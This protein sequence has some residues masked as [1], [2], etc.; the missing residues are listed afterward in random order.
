MKK[1]ESRVLALLIAMVLGVSCPISSMAASDEQLTD[2][3]QDEEIYVTSEEGEDDQ[4][5]R[6]QDDLLLDTESDYSESEASADDMVE[7]AVSETQDQEIGILDDALK[8]TGSDSLGRMI[9]SSLSEKVEEQKSNNGNNIFSVEIVG[10]KATVEYEVAQEAELVVGIYEEDGVKLLATGKNT[11]LPDEEIAEVEIDI[12][13]MPKYFYVKV[14]LILASTLEPLCSQFESPDYTKEM[15]EFFA[16]T[17]AD[18]DE[19]LVLNLDDNSA[20]NF[21]VFSEGVVRVSES[22]TQNTLIGADDNSLTYQFGNINA[23]IRDLKQGDILSYECLD[24]SI[25]ILLIESVNLSDDMSIAS[26]TGKTSSMEEAFEYIKIDSESMDEDVTID[27]SELEDGISYIGNLSNDEIENHFSIDGPD[28]D[29]A[30]MPR[31]KASSVDLSFKTKATF[32]IKRKLIEGSVGLSFKGKIKYYVSASHQSLTL[33]LD[34]EFSL[35][36]SSTGIEPFTIPLGKFGISPITG[37]FIEFTPSFILEPDSKTSVKITY[38]GTVGTSFDSKTKWHDASKKPKLKASIKNEINAFIGIS[39]EPK[40]AILSDK[41]ANAKMTAKTG[42][43]VSVDKDKKIKEDV[44]H[45]CEICYGG[46][47][48]YVISC[49]FSI[50]FLNLRS[51]KYSNKLE[52]N[53]KLDD[54]HYSYDNDEFSFSKCPHKVYPTEFTVKDTKGQP[55]QAAEIKTSTPFTVY[56][57]FGLRNENA[58]YTTK[59]GTIKGYLPKGNY[60]IVVSGDRHNEKTVSLKVKEKPGTKKITLSAKGSSDDSGDDD[61]D[62]DGGD[63]DDDEPTI[64]AKVSKLATSDKNSAIISPE[65]DLYVTG[66]NTYGELGIGENSK[67]TQSLVFRNIMSGVADVDLGERSGIAL[68]KDGTVWTWGYNQNGQIGNGT[69]SNAYTPVKVIDGVR[70]ISSVGATCGAVKNDNSLWMWGAK[71]TRRGEPYDGHPVRYYRS[72]LYP[73][74]IMDNVLYVCIHSDVNAV[75]KTDGS[76]WMWGCNEHGY[77]G[78]GNTED[79]LEPIKVLDNVK[80][81]DISGA[82][83]AAIKKDGSLWMWGLNSNGQFGNGTTTDSMIPIKILDNVKDV[84]V[85]G[86]YSSGQTAIIKEDDSLWISGQANLFVGSGYNTVTNNFVK[87]LSEVKDADFNKD[88]SHDGAIKKDGSLWRWGNNYFGQYGNGNNNSSYS[89]ICINNAYKVNAGMIQLTSCYGVDKEQDVILSAD[90]LSDKDEWVIAEDSAINYSSEILERHFDSLVPYTNYNFYVLSDEYYYDPLDSSNILYLTQGQTDGNGDLSIKYIPRVDDPDA[91]AFVVKQWEYKENEIEDD[92]IDEYAEVPDGLWMAGLSA[93][94]YDGTNQT[95]NV[96][97]YDG[98]TLLTENTDYTLSYKNNKK[99]FGYLPD[100]ADEAKK[101]PQITITMKGNYAGKQTVYFVIDPLSI[102]DPAAFDVTFKTSGKKTS[103]V[104]SHNGK[105]LKVNTDYTVR[106]EGTK[107][108]LEGIG[109]YVGTIKISKSDSKANTLVSMSKVKVAAVSSLTYKGSAYTETD[110][111]EYLKNAVTY[112]KSALVINE[113]FIVSKVIDSKNVGT[114]TVVLKGLKDTT[115]TNAFYG[116]KRIKI[117]IAPYPISGE[118]IAISSAEG[119]VRISAEY[120]KGG[121][122]PEI[123]IRYNG[124]NLKNGRDYTLTYKNNKAINNSGE[125]KKAPIISISGKGNFGGKTTV[126]FTIEQ[127]GFSSQNGIRVLAAD[128]HVSKDT[129]KYA[130]KISV[131]DKDGAL[132]KA[133]TDYKKEIVYKKG[134]TVL[135]KSST[136]SVGDEITVEVTGAGKNYSGDTISATYRILP[137]NTDISKA[138]IK[139]KDQAYTGSAVRITSS[140]QILASYIGKSKTPLNISVDGGKT[141]DFIVVEGSYV[142]NVSKGTAKVTLKGINNYGGYKTV[143]FKIGARSLK[144]WWIDLLAG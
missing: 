133:G 65:G 59:A 64:I 94:T 124:K 10:K 122:K 114:A 20:N 13:T 103:P 15:Q 120:T 8:V 62:D 115:R 49:S 66:S 105:K 106:D 74:K 97:I 96:R 137:E 52:F 108:I 90:A 119:N 136:V 77:L 29:Y 44:I 121:A 26:I 27:T 84:F 79:S 89:P 92:D 7:E 34:Y 118:D 73:E 60:S 140:S 127:T 78:N 87:V 47:I 85:G 111:S 95:Q 141:G 54:W 69:T 104:L 117:K 35:S 125:G 123:F 14:N 68:K 40:V 128:L 109:N 18:Y 39:F 2:E 61:D 83:V 71:Y 86:Y 55:I 37:V 4:A 43:K 50:Q 134:D 38:S 42:F 9:S 57:E 25:I 72:T 58:I 101:A 67:T 23:D 48:D 112:N 32:D 135:D 63:E 110:I 17:T 99:A 41:V 113:D 139:I 130:T 144:D 30:G 81:V 116:E 24:G 142:K 22:D 132:L 76:L 21:L 36:V 88:G 31:V 16:S 102:E 46:G 5:D 107:Y 11:V 12:D 91:T 1:H 129:N 131:Y 75:I 70:Q 56:D 33:T 93:L 45:L 143:T 3:F 80:K 126:N 28:Y 98:Q 82:H 100:N 53:A 6:D 19:E 51:L 138:T